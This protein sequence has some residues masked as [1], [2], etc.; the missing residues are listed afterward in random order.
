MK[1]LYVV[2]IIV[3]IL[4]M[5]KLKPKKLNLPNEIKSVGY[6]DSLTYLTPKSSLQQRSL[7]CENDEENYCKM[8]FHF[9]ILPLIYIKDFSGAQPES[10]PPMDYQTIYGDIFD[11]HNWGWG[12]LG[13]ATNIYCHPRRHPR[14]PCLLH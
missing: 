8:E 4:Q 1:G 10:F 14:R 5:H 13:H 6:Q 7:N 11:V 12:L 9:S 2:V 3:P